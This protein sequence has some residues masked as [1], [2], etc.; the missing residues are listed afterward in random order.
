M[1]ATVAQV[2]EL[3]NGIAPFELAESWDN[4]GLLA[5]RPDAKVDRVLCALDMSLAVIGEAERKGVQLIV[6]HHPILFRGRKN[7]R[8]TDAEGRM[9]C[10]LVRSG[11]AMI[12]AHTNYD[13]AEPGVN[14]A[15]AAALGLK[16]VRVLE[17]G[18]RMGN[19]KQTD[20]GSFA[21]FAEAA[22][23][24]PIRRYGDP[25]RRI[26]RVAV[27]GGA[28]EDYAGIAMENGADVYLT[29]EMAYHKAL[30]A[31]DNGLCVLEAGHAATEYPAISAL[32]RG[33]QIA[34]NAVQYDICV[35]KSEAE[36]FF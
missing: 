33:L 10:A 19:P 4:V 11:I 34:A 9:L 31:Q 26:E 28:G 16:D 6:T 22:L 20:F 18:M 29:G 5:G 27:L 17:S 35:L 32:C 2:L 15:L 23:G 14:D 13:N 8:E 12:A 24:G 30:D 21:T 1:S 25:K 36:L 3:V 7:L